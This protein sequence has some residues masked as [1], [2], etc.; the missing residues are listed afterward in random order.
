LPQRSSVGLAAARRAQTI[1]E[2][3]SVELRALVAIDREGDDSAE[4]T[5]AD[6][7]DGQMSGAEK[8]PDV[9]RKP[10]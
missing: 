5:P 1:P 3:K 7:V 6:L 2:T 9:T 8:A 10:P 4:A